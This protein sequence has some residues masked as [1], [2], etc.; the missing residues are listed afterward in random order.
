MTRETDDGNN[1][2]IIADAQT[3]VHSNR[4]IEKQREEDCLSA[5][6]TRVR[7]G[8][9]ARRLRGSGGDRRGGCRDKR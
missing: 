8:G 3:H 5:D 4:E 9:N 1:I 2:T 6:E 7:G